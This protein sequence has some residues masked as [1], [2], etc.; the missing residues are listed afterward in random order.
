MGAAERSQKYC[1]EQLSDG[2]CFDYWKISQRLRDLFDCP[3]KKA[4][5]QAILLHENAVDKGSDLKNQLSNGNHYPI[6][7]LRT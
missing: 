3:A 4:V 5:E 1:T 2:T 6:P 7:L